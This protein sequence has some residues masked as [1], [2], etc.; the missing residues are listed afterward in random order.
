MSADPSRPDGGAPHSSPNPIPPTDLS[1]APAI[2]SV[3]QPGVPPFLRHAIAAPQGDEA[4][5]VAITEVSLTPAPNGGAAV[6]SPA[7]PTAPNA[8]AT[9][10]IPPVPDGVDSANGVAVPTVAEEK[11]I[12]SQQKKEKQKEADAKIQNEQERIRISQEKLDICR[13]YFI[14]GC[15]GLPW[16]HFLSVMYFFNELSGE[17]GEFH[18]RK[19][20]LLSLIVGLIESFIWILWFVV[21]Q[22]SPDDS[23]V[24]GLGI[25]SSN[26]TLVGKLAR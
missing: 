10:Q 8:P 23:P 7:L 26:H 13:N 5:A 17:D 12:R 11:A 6:T 4:T 19:Y 1:F 16:L 3:L 2:A 15:F 9:G 22:V 25:V 21:F 14:V 24:K 20:I 18:T